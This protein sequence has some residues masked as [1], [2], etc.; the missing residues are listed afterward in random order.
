[1]GTIISFYKYMIDNHIKD[2]SPIGDLAR[3]MK[4]DQDFPKRSICFTTIYYYLIKKCACSDCNDAFCEAWK[5][6]KA[7][8]DQH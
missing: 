2:D 6:Y 4:S 8:R 7:W 1:M 3:D 5:E